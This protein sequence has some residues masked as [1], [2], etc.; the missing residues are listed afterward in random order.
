M[1]GRRGEP[2]LKPPYPAEAG[3][4]GM[5]TNVNNVE[6]F[7]NVPIIFEK[8]PEWFASIGTEKSKGTKVFALAGKINNV[9]LIEVPMGTTLREVIYEIG[10]GIKGGKK[11]KAVQTGGP[12]G[13]CLTEK[14]LDLPIDYDKLVGCRLNDGFRWYDCHGR[15]RLYGVCGS[16]LFGLHRG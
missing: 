14:H 6:T 10:G 2:T 16:L 8:G 3:Y 1:E 7:A 9:G 13:G 12:S 4:K 15:R 11:F 5:P